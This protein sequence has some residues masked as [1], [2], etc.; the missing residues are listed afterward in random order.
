MDNLKEPDPPRTTRRGQGR[1]PNPTLQETVWFARRRGE[2]GRPRGAGSFV[3][4]LEA[5]TGRSVKREKPGPQ[6]QGRQ[7]SIVSPD[8]VM[9][10]P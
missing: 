9:L 7:L 1:R 4:S 2:F 8:L 10:Y 5:R 6:A 3:E